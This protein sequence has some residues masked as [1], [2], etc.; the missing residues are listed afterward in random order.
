MNSKNNEQASSRP[1][2]TEEFETALE[3][4]GSRYILR[5]YVSGMTPRSQRAIEN[6][7]NIFET[8][9]KGSYDLE[10]IDVYQHPEQ[11]KESQILAVPML[12][13]QLPL[14]IRRLI[15][16]MSDEERVLVGL[17]IRKTE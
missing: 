3:R 8:S 14:P 5:L 17:G 15:G 4:K 9:Y 16:D 13:K 10:V 11:A 1:P 6:I 7:K 12:I 2:T